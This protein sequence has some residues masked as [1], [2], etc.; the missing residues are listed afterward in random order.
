MPHKCETCQ[1][2]F[3]RKSRLTYHLKLKHGN[4]ANQEG[5]EL[6]KCPFCENKYRDKKELLLH[7]DSNHEESRVFS[8]RRGAI[9]DKVCIF[10]QEL[11]HLKSSLQDFCNSKQTIEN[12]FNLLK[13]QFTHR[14]VFR[15]SITITADY[16][17]QGLDEEN[18]G[19]SIDID[20]FTL[21]SKGVVV[22]KYQSDRQIQK[23]IKS[24]LAGSVER[25]DDLL[26]RGSGW[27][28]ARLQSCSVLIYDCSS[29]KKKKK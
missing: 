27:R 25:E 17:I 29:I 2:S 9:G 20:S 10:Q 4:Q 22:N 6:R 21:R 23:R 12:V 28:F 18:Q 24:L 11:T 15:I 16:E 5:R 14:V 1:I 19:K 7:V 3:S 13:S 8:K 26:T